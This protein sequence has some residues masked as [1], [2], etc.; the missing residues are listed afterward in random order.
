MGHRG[1]GLGGRLLRLSVRRRR[2]LRVDGVE[3]GAR[4]WDYRALVKE[5]LEK[6]RR[7]VRCYRLDE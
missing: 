7:L 5:A 6:L 3:R 4:L 2:V 1:G